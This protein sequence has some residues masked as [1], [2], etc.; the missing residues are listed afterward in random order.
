MNVTS[1]GSETPEVT[2]N[3]TRMDALTLT[4]TV[5]NAAALLTCGCGTVGNVWVI[6]LLGFRVRRNPFCVYV[7]NLAVADLLFLVCMASLVSLDIL[8]SRKGILV[9][10]EVVK[11]TKYFAYMTSLS[12]LSAISTQRCLSVV[13]PIWYKLHQHRHMSTC[14]CTLLWGLSL[15]MN[16]LA[17]FF[18]SQLRDSDK[19]QC[20]I[21]DTVVITLILGVF[22]PLMVLS[23][24]LLFV[25][26]QKASRQWRR[27]PSRLLVVIV[28]SVFVFLVFSLP[29]GIY[30]FFLYWI[31]LSHQLLKLYISIARVSSSLSS[32][33]NPVIYILVGRWR[34]Q[35]RRE[36]LG[37]MLGRVLRE[38]LERPGKDTPSIVTSEKDSETQLSGVTAQ[39]RPDLAAVSSPGWEALKPEVWQGCF[40][41]I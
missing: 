19:D 4:C 12:L 23:S 26:I 24:L 41:H 18:C 40:L 14:V 32:S 28:S 25:R 11:R 2:H 3:E 9:F 33:A 17:S 20:S 31:E 35:S 21:V 27:R 34:S 16:M 22:T 29:L 39:I 30:W 7:L 37:A 5:L 13:F 36:S 8:F 6:W 10:Q 1:N 15:L 38:D